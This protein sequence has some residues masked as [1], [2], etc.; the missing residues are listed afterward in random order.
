M[1][2]LVIGLSLGVGVAAA[3]LAAQDVAP[4]PGF[5]LGDWIQRDGEGQAEESWSSDASGMRGVSREVSGNGVKF[6]ETLK[7]ERRD[8]TLVLIAQP[9]GS[10]PVAFAMV[11]HDERSIAFANAAHDY[12]QR[13]RYWRVGDTLHAEIALIDGSDPV[14]WSYVAAGR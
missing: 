8:G 2:R 10:E 11:E 13:I 14:S 1:R 9:A 6:Q 7:I 4:L 12:P 5:L 3:Q